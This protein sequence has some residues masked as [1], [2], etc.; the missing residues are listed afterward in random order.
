MAQYNF[1]KWLHV[2]RILEISSAH[3]N[4]RVF[5]ISKPFNIWPHFTK[6]SL[7]QNF[8]G[9]YE[10]RL[11]YDLVKVVFRAGFAIA[12]PQLRFS[13]FN[14]IHEFRL[15]SVKCQDNVL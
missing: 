12:P 1:H 11:E 7:V 5:G 3:S 8:E 4:L 15:L 2:L 13:W 9:L 14:C 10:I 6:T